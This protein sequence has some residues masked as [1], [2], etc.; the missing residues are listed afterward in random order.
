[1]E[2]T[3]SESLPYVEVA[4]TLADEVVGRV[5][6]SSFTYDY[7]LGLF[8]RCLHEIAGEVLLPDCDT[9]DDLT[10]DAGTNRV[11][12]PPRFHRDLRHCHSTSHN[13]P[14]KVHG[15]LSQLYRMFSNLDQS[16]VVCGVAVKG[17]YMY[18]QRVPSS[19]ET[20][21]INYW[22]YPEKL[23]SRDDKPDD[24]PGH[25]HE[26]LLVNYACWR[27][28]EQIED[29]VEGA[30]V[31][32]QYYQQEYYKAKA[33]LKVF[34]GPEERVPLDIEEAVPWNDWAYGYGFQGF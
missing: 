21:R 2:A 12:L 4:H 17:R 27:I 33:E 14:I 1:M 28:Y 5:Q 26:A 15:S 18:Y 23:A 22:R 9:W 16:G 3:G 7:I 31:N 6:D 19:A 20:L 34:V 32:T 30:K 13:R 8:N 25:L 24:L 29:G 11:L 10:T